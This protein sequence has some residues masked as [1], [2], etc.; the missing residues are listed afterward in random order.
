MVGNSTG[1]VIVLALNTP[2]ATGKSKY[3]ASDLVDLYYQQSKNIFKTSIFRKLYTGFG[4]WG[5]KYDRSEYDKILLEFFGK[6]R[7]S[8]LIKPTVVISYNLNAELPHVW[9]REFAREKPYRDFLVSDIAAATS[10]A[11]TY[12]APKLLTDM[13][14]N[15]EYQV[16]GGIFANNPESAAISLAYRLNNTL[17]LK[18]IVLISLGTGTIKLATNPVNLGGAGIIGWVINANLIDVMMGA[19]SDWYDAEIGKACFNSCRLQFELTRETSAMDNSSQNNLDTLIKL[20]E[21]Y[22]DDNSDLI[23]HIVTILNE[24]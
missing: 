15:I 2:D 24:N 13:H 12:F 1:G 16:D 18:D 17:E 22:I 23:D 11:P 19:Q 20:T 3:Q 9:S 10:S 6:I 5:P 14:N 4:L 8:Q 21:K 7:M